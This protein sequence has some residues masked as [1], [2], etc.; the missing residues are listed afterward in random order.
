VARRTRGSAA[1]PL[2][3]APASV[4]LRLPAHSASAPAPS[5]LTSTLGHAAP[6]RVL[7][8]AFARA[9]AIA[10]ARVVAMASARVTPPRHRAHALSRSCNR[11]G[12]HYSA[13]SHRRASPH[14]YAVACVTPSR[15]ARPRVSLSGLY[16]RGPLV[17]RG[18]TSAR[19]RRSRPRLSLVIRP[20]AQVRLIRLHFD[21]RARLAPRPL[22]TPLYIW[23]GAVVVNTRDFPHRRLP[24]HAPLDEHVQR[25]PGRGFV[26][27]QCLGCV[28][29][30]D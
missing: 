3:A 27:R 23:Q 20:R 18:R 2:S 12:P 28:R 16:L 15:T 1:L 14:R 10:S 4:P 30:R 22:L 25:E 6:A 9:G 29:D 26:R 13:L 19:P 7:L 21:R 24:A 8:H 17:P 5:A 11:A